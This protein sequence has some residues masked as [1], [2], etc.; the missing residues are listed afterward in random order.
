MK[1]RDSQL[2]ELKAK[3][4]EYPGDALIPVDSVGL[5]D[6]CKRV[7]KTTGLS[8]IKFSAVSGT[9]ERTILD[10]EKGRTKQIQNKQLQRLIELIPERYTPGYNT[11]FVK[12]EVF[13]PTSHALTEVQKQEHCYCITIPRGFRKKNRL[14]RGDFVLLQVGEDFLIKK[15][16]KGFGLSI[17]TKTCEKCMQEGKLPVKWFYRISNNFQ[18][19]S[20]PFSRETIDLIVVLSGMGTN[21][22]LISYTLHPMDKSKALLSFAGSHRTLILNRFLKRDKLLLALGYWK[23]DGNS[24]YISLS[25]MELPLL[26]DFIDCVNGFG[27]KNTD[28]SAKL[29]VYENSTNRVKLRLRWSKELGIPPENFYEDQILPWVGDSNTSYISLKLVQNKAFFM[30][31]SRLYELAYKTA[32]AD[33]NVAMDLLKGLLG[34]DG[35]VKT[36]NGRL[37]CVRVHCSSREDALKIKKIC[38]TLFE[39]VTL[40][41]DKQIYRN[42]YIGRKKNFAI[43]AK[44]INPFG[45]NEKRNR[46]FFEAFT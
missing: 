36:V 18:P 41:P 17:P 20:S 16:Q 46:K 45:A 28:W 21:E 9:S 11:A 30:V 5:A 22:S 42:V 6:L 10:R 13:D 37:S 26:K 8:Q 3:L 38:E 7:R 44:E 24:R 25:N 31:W 4:S 23:S 40:S 1:G 35:S 33:K 43:L 15:V 34:G 14:K 32:L 12:L 29:I 2:A 19:A 39:G 27:F